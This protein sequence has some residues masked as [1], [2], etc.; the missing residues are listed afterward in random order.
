MFIFPQGSTSV[1]V[2]LWIKDSGTG[3]G[4]TGLVYNSAGLVAS[5]VRPRTNRTG[6]TLV[7]QTVPGA[8]SSG[9]FVEVDG[10]NMPG[11]YRFDVPNAALAAGE[12]YCIVHLQKSDAIADPLL[13]LLDALPDIQTGAVVA[14]GS[15][16]ATT[17][18]TDLASTTNDFYKDS[19]LLFRTGSLAGQ[20]KKI[21]GY[22]GSSKFVTVPAF[23]GVPSSNDLFTIVNR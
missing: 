13:I 10:T 18:K 20:Q 22:N 2:Y 1:T 3:A 11:L 8:W 19:Y 6:I 21:L 17:F 4:K 9:G 14:D 23:T 5:Y 12:N 16:T 7:T 15:N